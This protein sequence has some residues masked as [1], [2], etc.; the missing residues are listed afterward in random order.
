ME[1]MFETPQIPADQSLRCGNDPL[2]YRQ[3]GQ[4]FPLINVHGWGGSSRYWYL[5]MRGLADQRTSY[6]LDLPGFGKSPARFTP[7]GVER[8]AK[9]VIEFADAMGLEQ[10][11][12]NG[13]SFGGGVAVL[14]AAHHP[15]RVRRLVL[16]CYGI[17]PSELEQLAAELIYLQ[18]FPVLEFWHPWLGLWQPL[19]RFWQFWLGSAGYMPTVPRFVSSPF[20]YNLPM[21]DDMLRLGY[22]EFLYMDQRT[23]LESVI[24]LG[25]P[26][27]R[28]AL[29]D[30]QAPT[31]LIG[32]RQDMV[33][34]PQRVERT[35]ALIPN[36]RLHWVDECGH[37]PMIEQ[38]AEYVRVLRKFLL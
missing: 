22:T 12:L 10:F 37:V 16:T 9:L 33:V 17:L 15:E 19:E 8:M 23:S 1:V 2:Y 4:G 7:G 13:H 38:S 32:T 35:A 27:L 24:S 5:P 6:A 28:A 30:I 20:F 3:L 34:L 21:D 26:R 25:T 18:T 11:D 31:L 36:S 29:P 14:V